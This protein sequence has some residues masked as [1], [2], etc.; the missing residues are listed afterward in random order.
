M[1]NGKF[2]DFKVFMAV[3]V[4]AL[5]ILAFL[6]SIGDS[7]T[8]QTSTFTNNNLSVT[9]PAANNTLAIQGRELVGTML[10]GNSTDLTGIGETYDTSNKI[11]N[12]VL[13]VA[14]TANDTSEAQGTGGNVTYT[15]EP[16]GFSDTAGARSILTTSLIIFTLA[17]LVFVIV[18]IMKGSMSNLM[19]FRRRR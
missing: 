6:G 16:D 18:M 17:L 10:I 8:A 2:G 4:G 1:A 12:G 3:F 9:L 15:F 13:T 19:N 11:V 7:I 14:I 5:I